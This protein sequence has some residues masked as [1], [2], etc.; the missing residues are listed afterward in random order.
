M[1]PVGAF[2]GLKIVDVN[3]LVASGQATVTHSESDIGVAAYLFD[4]NDGTL[5][6]SAEID[7]MV[8]RVVFAES[9]VIGRVGGIFSHSAT[10][11]EWMAEGAMSISDL[12]GQ[13]RSYRSLANWQKVGDDIWSKVPVS[14]SAKLKVIEFTIQRPGPNDHIHV[15]GLE[16]AQGPPPLEF[17]AV[18]RDPI[19]RQVGVTWQSERGETY[20]VFGSG[21]IIT[22]NPLGTFEADATLSTYW[23]PDSASRDRRIYKVRPYVE[24]LADLD[25][26]FVERTPRYDYDATKG[27]PDPGDSVT[28]HAHVRNSGGT[29][30]PSVY[31]VWAIDGTPNVT[32]TLTSILPGEERVVDW[33]RVW[34]DGTHTVGFTIDPTDEIHE[35]T[36]ENNDAVDRTNGLAVGFWVEQT[37]YDYFHEYQLELGLGSNS[38]E[39]WAQ[40]HI[41]HLNQMFEDAVWPLTPDGVFDRVRL[42][43]VVVVPDGALPLAGGLPSNHPDR[44]D[45]TVDMMWGFAK[46]LVD[47]G[48]YPVNS[49][50]PFNY[51][52]S[53]IHELN[54]ARYLIDTYGFDVHGSQVQIEE[55]GVPIPGTSYMPYIA[56][57]VVHYNNEGGMMSGD[58]TWL[59][60]YDAACWNRI[61]GRRAK[62]GNYSTPSSSGEWLNT[63]L[64]ASNK[65]TV[66]NRFGAPI[67][68]ANV[69]IYQ[70]TGGTGWY[71]KTFDD[72]P[73]LY[74]TTDGDGAVVL[75]QNPFGEPIRHTDGIANGVLIWRIDASGKIY[76]RFQEVTE[77]HK[78]FWAGR[79]NMGELTIQTDHP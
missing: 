62:G 75:P 8:V 37:V 27:W 73:D 72:I 39:D 58:Y 21:D 52:G 74:L 63:D 11:H 64:P 26:M 59:S 23:D 49:G 44:G 13:T 76:Y 78:E 56:G 77:Y 18:Q 66:V 2:G 6:R 57:E 32:G 69:E 67:A 45:K 34:Q 42:D 28:F 22:W 15:N 36:E 55:G 19:S 7:P 5:L 46:T 54:H 43:K 50:G 47:S 12:E 79:T 24:A 9:Q 41:R 29:T 53:L 33:R 71:A 16:L 1:L 20:K 60:E 40:R 68:G 38:W 25:V 30:V 51:E 4:R 3:A 70:A 48:F 61:T 35:I 65:V 10:G 14:P 31:Y 17:V